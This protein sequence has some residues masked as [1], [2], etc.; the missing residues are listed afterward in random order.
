MRYDKCVEVY[1]TGSSDGVYNLLYTVGDKSK[2]VIRLAYS[3]KHYDVLE[4]YQEQENTLTLGGT[5]KRVRT[6]ASAV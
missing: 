3:G 5:V 4:P 2:P 6:N 1:I